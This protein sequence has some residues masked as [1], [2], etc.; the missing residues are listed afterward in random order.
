MD[1]LTLLAAQAYISRGWAVFPLQE[2]SKI[3]AVSGGVSASSTDPDQIQAWFGDG[4]YFKYNIGIR[5]GDTLAIVDE[6]FQHGGHDSIR[7]LPVADFV[8]PTVKTPRGGHHYYYLPDSRPLKAWVGFLPGVDL[9]VNNSYVVAP[10][11]V[12]NGVAYEWVRTAN[13]LPLAPLPDWVK[14][15]EKAGKTVKPYQDPTPILPGRWHTTMT[16]IAG[17]EVSRSQTEEELLGRL[18]AISRARSGPNDKEHTEQDIAHLGRIASDAWADW[19]K[20]RN[21][22]RTERGQSLYFA[23][24]Y[25]GI[26]RYSHRANSWYFFQDHWWVKD[27]GGK[28]KHLIENSIDHRAAKIGNLPDEQKEGERKFIGKCGHSAVLRGIFDIAKNNPTV[29]RSQI[30]WEPDPSLLGVMNGVVDLKTGELLP[31]TPEQMIY[32]HTRV[33]YNPDAKAPR[34]ERFIQEIFAGDQDLIFFVQR[35]LGLSLT[36]L[37]KEQVFFLC[38]GSGSNGKSTL[39]QTVRNVIGDYGMNARIE[40]FVTKGPSG[41]STIPNDIMEMKGRRFVI[42]SEPPSTVTLDESR[43]KMLTGG[44]NTRARLLNKNEEEFTPVPKIWISFN[45]KPNIRDDTNSFWRRV[46][47]I[48]FTVKFAGDNRDI[49]IQ[50]DLAKEHEGILAWLVQGAVSYYINRLVTPAAVLASTEEYRTE[51]DKFGQFIADT[52][53]TGRFVSKKDVKT[54]YREWRS[55]EGDNDVRPWELTE[56]DK[57]LATDYGRKKV[58]GNRGYGAELRNPPVTGQTVEKVGY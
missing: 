54:A 52:L 29:G 7:A 46:R 14:E 25:Q 11:S 19:K 2:N 8:T 31:G 6:D 30:E 17:V 22:E 41:S 37:T 48:P 35:A 34:W 9:R 21:F 12:I 49:N 20:V 47:F 23:D 38:Y 57:R 53:Q 18:I 51:S 45:K 13:D 15:P 26:A 44:E 32:L 24:L 43:L 50:E 55:G 28:I 5:A 40:T 58:D 10:P 16:S 39:L 4:N 27:D 3:P 36:G 42:T 1:D 33:P 56:L